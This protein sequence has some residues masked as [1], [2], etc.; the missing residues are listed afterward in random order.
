VFA[1]ENINFS[2]RRIQNYYFNAS[3][4]RQT[5]L[6]IWRILDLQ[7]CIYV[8]FTFVSSQRIFFESEGVLSRFYFL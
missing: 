6:N 4:S 5:F 1:A 2:E 3:E 8:S 7:K